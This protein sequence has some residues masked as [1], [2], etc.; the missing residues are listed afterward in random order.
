MNVFNDSGVGVRLVAKDY[1]TLG[2]VASAWEMP[3]HDV[4][5]LA[6]TGLMRLSARICRTHL[7]RGVWELEEDAGW[8]QVPQE[9]T[10]YTGLVDLKDKD[11]YLIFRDGACEISSFHMAQGIYF[12]VREPS[13]PVIVY[14]ADLLIRA[15]ERRR[16]ELSNGRPDK[17]LAPSQFSHDAGYVHVEFRGRRF[18]FGR[19]QAHIVRQLHEAS[20]TP[21]PWCN[22]SDLLEQASSGCYRLVDAFKSQPHWRELILSDKR[23]AFRLAIPPS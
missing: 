20:F 4:V 13:D 23:G 5:Y 21:T 3:R 10:R 12:E 15:E 11:A 7:E 2:E 19:I 18:R 16:L 1:Y 22:G 14:E 8:F 9:R 6:E 17:V